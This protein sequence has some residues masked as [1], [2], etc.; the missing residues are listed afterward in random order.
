MNTNN[1]LRN[2]VF[3]TSS[4]DELI[5]NVLWFRKYFQ[6]ALLTLAAITVTLSTIDAQ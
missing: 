6:E 3:Y 2:N 5:R 1:D 4:K